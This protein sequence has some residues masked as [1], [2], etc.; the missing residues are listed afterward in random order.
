MTTTVTAAPYIYR[1]ASV[2]IVTATRKLVTVPPPSPV[3][4]AV[5]TG[6]TVETISGDQPTRKDAIRTNTSVIRNAANAPTK[7]LHATK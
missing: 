7:P 3:T 4:V 5:T 2:T 6:A 1:D